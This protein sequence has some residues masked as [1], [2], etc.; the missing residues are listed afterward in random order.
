MFIS[1]SVSLYKIFASPAVSSLTLK[2]VISVL[3]TNRSRILNVAC[4]PTRDRAWSSSLPKN[5]PTQ[6]AAV[7]LKDL[8]V[9]TCLSDSSWTRCQNAVGVPRPCGLAPSAPDCELR[10]VDLH[11]SPP[12]EHCIPRAFTWRG[13]SSLWDHVTWTSELESS[14]RLV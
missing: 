14:L 10:A 8:L 5:Q 9:T 3:S 2:I 13:W 4:V 11:L 12:S 6:R 7:V 1:P